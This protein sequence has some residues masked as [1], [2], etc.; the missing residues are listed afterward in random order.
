MR[1]VIDILYLTNLLSQRI[2]TE[3]RKNPIIGEILTDK[4]DKKDLTETALRI[5][6]NTYNK[7][8]RFPFEVWDDDSA[9]RTWFDGYTI[10]PVG[11]GN[12][13]EELYDDPSQELFREVIDPFIV[14]V[15][16]YLK[17]LRFKKDWTW[18]EHIIVEIRATTVIMEKLGDWRIRDWER[19]QKEKN[20]SKYY[21]PI[22]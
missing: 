15:V 6:W 18:E 1:Y 12:N 22:D 11:F 5:F 2:E 16:R 21:V 4:V 8:S 20:E 3:R 9:I 17:K 13:N 10:E 7:D 14:D 19:I